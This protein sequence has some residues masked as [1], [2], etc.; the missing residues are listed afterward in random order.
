MSETHD[1]ADLSTAEVGPASRQVDST[2][3]LQLDLVLGGGV[4]R[5]S[6]LMVVGPPGS[7]KTTLAA[8]MAFAAARAGRA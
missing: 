5:G 1:D 8:Q 3:A 6:L 7:G 4:P 2:G